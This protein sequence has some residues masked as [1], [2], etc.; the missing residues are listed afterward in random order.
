MAKKI[1]LIALFVILIDQISK[2]VVKKFF[3]YEKNF[4]ATFGLFRGQLWLFILTALIV[5]VLILY[6]SKKVKSYAIIA[7]GF[8]L[9][10]TVAN[11]IDR[12]FL[13]YVI[14][15]I[16]IFKWPAFNI[17]DIANVVGV[18]LLLIYLVKTKK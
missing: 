11:L 16:S 12:I 1:F 17:A 8:L 9:G 2:L 13:G 4:G 15:F 3:S 14:D 18:L 6:Y 7:L 5:I 10:G